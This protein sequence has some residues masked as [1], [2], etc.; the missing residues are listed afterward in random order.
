MS[1]GEFVLYTLNDQYTYG[2]VYNLYFNYTSSSAD[3]AITVM[4]NNE[5]LEN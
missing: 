1:S 4:L 2:A 5:V 3:A